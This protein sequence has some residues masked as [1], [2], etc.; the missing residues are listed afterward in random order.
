MQLKDI[1]K[2]VDSHTASIARLTRNDMPTLKEKL[3][4]EKASK[5]KVCYTSRIPYRIC[6]LGSVLY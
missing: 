6:F 2:M 4:K 5:K 1:E 3:Y